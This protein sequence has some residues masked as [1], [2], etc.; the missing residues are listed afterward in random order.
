M[1]PSYEHLKDRGRR[2]FRAT[3]DDMTMEATLETQELSQVLLH[4]FHTRL[5]SIIQETGE[6]PK[7]ETIFSEPKTALLQGITLEAKKANKWESHVSRKSPI[8]TAVITSR[9]KIELLLQ[10]FIAKGSDAAI[11]YVNRLLK[12]S[13]NQTE[14][15]KKQAEEALRKQGES[16][17]A[18]RKTNLR[19]AEAVGKFQ[20]NRHMLLKQQA[21]LEAEK[22]QLLL[23]Q[24]QLRQKMKMAIK[25]TERTVQRNRQLEK[26]FEEDKIALRLAKEQIQNIEAELERRKKTGEIFT[27]IDTKLQSLATS[28]TTGLE[29]FNSVLT[30]LEELRRQQE[31]F[32][33][34]NLSYWREVKKFEETRLLNETLM[35]DLEAQKRLTEQA[36]FA[37]ILDKRFNDNEHISRGYCA[38]LIEYF[39]LSLREHDKDFKNHS[40][41]E[42]SVTKVREFF[43]LLNSRWLDPLEIGKKK[44]QEAK[45]SWKNRED[46]WEYALSR[47][48]IE[49]V[50]INTVDFLENLLQNNKAISFYTDVRDTETV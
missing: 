49:W 6:I 32:I 4:L 41:L 48:N 3:Y 30:E 31:K 13:S 21:V 42:E 47:T 46:L 44:L 11:G 37:A 40:D 8:Y 14:V 2:I 39:A 50:Y 36:G 35:R 9:E 26:T 23:E 45:H 15:F 34:Q 18:R 29:K 5:L 27:I 28:G 10:S 12:E 43:F 38:A 16:E 22:S 17:E 19:L 20:T 1:N 25:E 7:M 33:Q 24:D